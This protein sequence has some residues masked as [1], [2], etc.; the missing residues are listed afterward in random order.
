MTETVPTGIYGLDEMMSGGFP[1]KRIILVLGGP[2]AGK[3]ILASQFLY[4][5][6][7]E[8]NENGIM[9]SLDENKHHFYSEMNNFGW[10]FKKAEEEWGP[11]WNLP[12]TQLKIQSEATEV[13]RHELINA[14]ET[15][16]YLDDIN[17]AEHQLAPVCCLCHD[18]WGT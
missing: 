14:P 10:D 13:L 15:K 17:E 12:F 3:T 6:L 1:K 8:F 11:G 2:G 16:A 4:K 9:V 7:S 5:G 18:H